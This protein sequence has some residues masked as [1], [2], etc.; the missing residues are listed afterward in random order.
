MRRLP[1]I[2][3]AAVLG[4]SM[5]EAAEITAPSEISSVTVFPTGAEIVRL[6]KVKVP[7]GE[8]TV[9]IDH[10][11]P[12]AMAGS[13][14]VEGKA[15]GRLDIGSVDT[16]RVL[17]PF[18]DPAQQASE[19]R[20]IELEIE[21][22]RDE[23]ARI[24]AEVKAT[25]AQK[26]LIAKLTELPTVA[27]QPGA[28]GVAAAV[29]WG[30]IF[31]LVGTK[32]AEAERAQLAARVKLRD[33]ERSIADLQKKLAAIAPGQQ[34]RTE[35]KVFVVA[36]ADLE[37]NLT[38]RYQVTNANWRPYYDARLETGTKSTAPKL[39]LVRRASI[40]QRSGEDWK[41]VAI[42]LSTTRPGTGTAAPDL[43]PLTVDFELERPPP[44]PVAAAPAPYATR[45]YK[46]REAAAGAAAPAAEALQD[47]TPREATIEAGA[48][49]AIFKVPGKLTVPGNG[50]QKRVQLDTAEIAPSLVVRT[51]P[52]LEA[53]AY[54]YAKLATPK[55]TPYL[56]GT[57][58]LFRDGTYVGTGPLPQLT[59]GEEHEIGFGADD[60]V[61]VRYAVIE[62]KRGESGLIT[63]SKSDVRNY[64]ITVKNAHAQ[65]VQLSVM[66]QIPVSQH[67]DI[68]V[69]LISKTP[70][71][72]RDV[73]DKRGVLAW[74]Q[75]IEAD[76][77]KTIE[78]GYRVT[79]PAAKKI[80]YG[81]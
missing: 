23:H 12:T 72:R 68:K 42:E 76:E 22:L 31:T 75:K 29:D 16:R 74:D 44:P 13:V 66:D 70:P 54:L 35:V 10:L 41:D 20:R 49:Q 63:S 1:I 62:E 3:F 50:E 2:V 18:G 81:R 25:D 73:D 79:W 38:I 77:E 15:T 56:P 80:E 69:E 36:A 4:S 7:A 40:Q 30:Q 37:A 46:R 58:S 59:P 64:R 45:S 11:P 19:R 33:V 57:V 24:E 78:F 51:A 21:T 26:A 67:Q 65:A 43:H 47:A 28:P 9:V 27:P 53:K 14:R 34:Q 55:G 39:T 17:V 52:R 61:R 32:L 6:A 71:S 8:H 60:A 5:T 48:F